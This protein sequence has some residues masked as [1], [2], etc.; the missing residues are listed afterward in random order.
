MI[1]GVGAELV[2]VGNGTPEMAHAFAEDIGLT[3]PLYTDPSRRSYGLAGLKR[4]V[5][6]TLSPRGVLHAARAVRKGFRQSATRGDPWQQGG[7]LVVDRGGR[8]AYAH[9]DDEAGDLAPIDEVVAAVES[10]RAKA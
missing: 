3:T 2:V 5:F 9:R 8:V 6:A 1:H 10:L 4:G 7:I